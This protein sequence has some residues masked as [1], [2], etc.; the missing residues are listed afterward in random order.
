[1]S[2]LCDSSRST[3]IVIDLQ[4]RLMPAIHKGS[5]VIRRAKILAQAAKILTV[6]VIGTAQSASKLGPNVAQISEYL[7]QTVAKDNFDS[8]AAAGFHAALPDSRSELIVVGCEA[9][10]CVLQTVLGLLNREYKVKLVA[11]AV[12]SRRPF[13]KAVALDRAAA[14]GAE[15]V[16][17]EMVVFEWLRDS[18]HP[19]FRQLI[20]L[21]K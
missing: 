2:D 14:A 10:V 16:T 19:E 1:M 13:D 4:E 9:H 12:G 3:L 8:C 17:S 15:I 18:N 7:D 20:A 5:E 21:V 6:P 11:D